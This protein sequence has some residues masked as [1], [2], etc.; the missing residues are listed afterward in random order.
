MVWSAPCHKQYQIYTYIVFLMQSCFCVPG[1]QSIR[2]VVLHILRGVASTCCITHSGHNVHCTCYRVHC[3]DYAMN[4]TINK[5]LPVELPALWQT[6]FVYLSYKC[7]AGSW[8][9]VGNMNP[10]STQQPTV[11]CSANTGGSVAD[12]TYDNPTYQI[13]SSSNFSLTPQ[14]TL[15]ILLQSWPQ[16]SY[17]FLVQLPQGSILIIAGLFMPRLAASAV[18]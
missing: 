11:S 2:I 14:L 3:S 10:S 6:L 7:G 4:F 15:T 12:P 18:L 9:V 1:I 16:N 5:D 17:P 8:W 13:M